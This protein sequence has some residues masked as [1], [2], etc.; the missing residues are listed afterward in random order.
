MKVF[1]PNKVFDREGQIEI[2]QMGI[3]SKP[4]QAKDF[5]EKPRKAIEN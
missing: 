5:Y 3:Y 4:I 2:L 1:F